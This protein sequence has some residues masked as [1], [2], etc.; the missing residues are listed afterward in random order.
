MHWYHFYLITIMIVGTVFAVHSY[1]QSRK[2]SNTVVTVMIFIF[3]AIQILQIYALYCGGF[4]N[5]M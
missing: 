3:L 4:W 1:V 5:N 2:Y